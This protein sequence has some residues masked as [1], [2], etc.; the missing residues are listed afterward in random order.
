VEAADVIVIPYLLLEMRWWDQ[1][2]TAPSP[3]PDG[4]C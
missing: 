4:Y 1:A 3:T 2:P